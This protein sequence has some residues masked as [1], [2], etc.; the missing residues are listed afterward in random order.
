MNNGMTGY[1]AVAPGD[2]VTA[3]NALAHSSN[4][5]RKSYKDNAEI[6]A[7]VNSVESHIDSLMK[8]LGLDLNTSAVLRGEQDDEIVSSSGMQSELPNL[9]HLP[10]A[11]QDFD[12]ESFL[13]QDFDPNAGLAGFDVG[14]AE[15]LGAFLD[16]VR[17]VS[18]GSDVTIESDMVE[19]A[20]RGG[21]IKVGT[22][23]KSDTVD[24]KTKKVKKR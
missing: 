22:K 24:L 21:E 15:Q 14:N 8:S 3:L 12:F 9:S 23:R 2:D 13:T 1:P 16:E 4:Q 17:S 11:N 6:E 20:N 7:D 10:E 18:G 5:L 19:G